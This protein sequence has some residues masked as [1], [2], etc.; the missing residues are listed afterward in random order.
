MYFK[1]SEQGE[2][3][4]KPCKKMGSITGIKCLVIYHWIIGHTYRG[5]NFGTKLSNFKRVL[6]I[7][8][9]L[10]FLAVISY[11]AYKMLIYVSKKGEKLDQQSY[12]KHLILIFL[13]N[14]RAIFNATQTIFYLV[15]L[16]IRGKHILEAIHS[17]DLS[18][19]ERK[20]ERKIGIIIT[21]TVFLTTFSYQWI[22]T[23]LYYKSGLID[24]T[25]DYL[26]V[27]PML[28][29][30][31]FNTHIIIISLIAYQSCVIHFQLKTISDNIPKHKLNYLYKFSLKLSKHIRNFDKLISIY[32]LTALAINS[33]ICISFVCKLCLDQSRSLGG[34][35]TLIESTGTLFGL[36]LVCDII[37]NSYREFCD[38]LSDYYY[39]SE[40]SCL[41]ADDESLSKLLYVRSILSHLFGIQNDL[42]FTAFGLFRVNTNTFISCVAF[43]TTHSVILIQTN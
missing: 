5:W 32:T 35:A 24:P 19:I 12:K 30:L 37:P 22:L 13:E 36:C 26:L 21:L 11:H 33:L 28:Y 27:A 4:I 1:R 16:L 15:F 2:K 18:Q 10:L 20:T 9:N 40:N 31:L 39:F 42:C 23:Y 34:I 14:A 38:K 41:T 6:L 29:F 25:V 17:W 43:I 8:W 3:P 7:L